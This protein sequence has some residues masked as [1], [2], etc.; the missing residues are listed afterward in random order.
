MTMTLA[1][2]LAL[3]AALL[4]AGGCATPP[5]G[6]TVA[7]PA[8][9]PCPAC[10]V[11]PGAPAA[12]LP[13]PPAAKPL[14]SAAWGELPGWP[15]EHPAAAAAA[16]IE[17][18]RVM[19]HKAQW[20]ALCEQARALAPG[21]AAAQRFFESRFDPWRVV[22]PDGGDE[23]LITGYYEPLLRG[24]RSRSAAFPH[25][26][27]GVPDDLL[28][29]EFG[30]L[31]PQLK[32]LRLCGRLEGRKVVPYYPRAELTRREAA[33][34]SRAIAWVA[35][36]VELFFL[37]IQGSGRVE[38][39]DGSRIRVGYAN[40]NGHPYRSIGRI[41]VER[42]E[43][44]AAQASMEGIKAWARAH[45]ERLGELL[46]SNPSYVFFRELDEGGPGPIG[47]Q[48]VAL[49]PERSLAVD[50]TVIPLGSPVF[51][52]ATWPNS[53]EPLR[54]LMVAQDTGGA[55]RGPVRADFFWGFG[56]EAGAR[57]GAMRQSGRLWVLLPR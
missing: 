11:C 1:R 57:A 55:I 42:G 14:Q 17:S 28:T 35:D 49:T 27:H 10:P 13:A 24:A 46:D 39:P 45:P 37:H 40:Q 34:E 43:L 48:G 12:A 16:L 41:L 8:S 7:C 47:A 32:A 19:E 53:T 23:G 29:I 51:L 36:P 31:F 33:L 21:D 9:V 6:R 30:D 26:I 2:G 54:R 38:L 56:H 18:C 20:Q 52:A 22:N 50:A 44:S 3:V 25:A 4:L 15:G 5:A